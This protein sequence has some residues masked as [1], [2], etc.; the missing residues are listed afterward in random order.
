[1]K[2]R[3]SFLRAIAVLFAF[4][5]I[6]TAIAKSSDIK[7]TSTVISVIQTDS[8]AGSIEVTI[9]DVI[10]PI[11]VNGDT[12]I[13]ESG[14]EIS[15]SDLSAGDFVGIT[16]FFTDEGLV[17]DD[18]KILEVREEQF[19]LR[20]SISAVDT[21]AENTVITLLGVDVTIT[22]ETS[23]TRRNNGDGNSVPASGLSANDLV[24]VSGSVTEGLLVATRIHVGTREQGNIELEGEILTLSDTELSLSIEGG[25]TV[26]VIIDD[27][28]S[29]VGELAEGVFIEVEGQLQADLAL[30]AFEIAADA[31]GDGDAD[32]DNQRGKRGDEHSNNGRG[33]G[34]G[35][36]NGNSGDDDDDDDSDSIEVGA[37]TLLTGDNSELSGKAEYSYE[38]DGDQIEQELE[39]EIEELEAGGEYSIIVFFGDESV[40]FGT[41]TSDTSGELEVKFKSDASDSDDN[42]LIDD[43]LPSENDVRDISKVQILQNEIVVFEGAF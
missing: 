19:R 33:N 12:E 3:K 27:D 16:S 14:E 39:I 4:A 34:N 15:I 29:I 11:I 38:E 2:A 31:D 30:T 40:N 35:N 26:A 7:F 43:L 24:N 18:I 9:H 1:M 21:I 41:F 8:N 25:T 17:A 28:T 23:I 6:N 42:V 10:I 37:E 5:C 20:G 22:S 13:G 36:G 32:D